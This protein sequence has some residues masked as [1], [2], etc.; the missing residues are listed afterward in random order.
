MPDGDERDSHHV[1]KKEK[2]IKR[3]GVFE[4]QELSVLSHPSVAASHTDVQH[5]LCFRH[6]FGASEQTNQS[7]L[8]IQVVQAAR[9]P[10]RGCLS[11]TGVL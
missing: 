11:C 9:K 7:G 8:Q 10:H 1:K 4:S 2:I 3:K 5:S 6:T